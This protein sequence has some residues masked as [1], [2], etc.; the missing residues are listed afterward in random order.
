VQ[1][2]NGECWSASF[3]TALRNDEEQFRAKSD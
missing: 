2:T 3:G 1:A